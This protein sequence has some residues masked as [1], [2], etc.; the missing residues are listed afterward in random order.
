MSLV[1]V[2]FFVWARAT[3]PRVR[4]DYFVEF[5]WRYVLLILVFSLFCIL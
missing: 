4:Y 3:L 1:H 2:V 5:M